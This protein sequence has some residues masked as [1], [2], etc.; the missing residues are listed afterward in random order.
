[1]GGTK[2][3]SGS[4]RYFQQSIAVSC[5]FFVASQAMRMR[6]V[7][8]CVTHLST[9]LLCTGL[10][11]PSV[12]LCTL[13]E[14]YNL[15]FVTQSTRSPAYTSR[16]SPCPPNTPLR[17]LSP[18]RHVAGRLRSTL[19]EW[20]VAFSQTSRRYTRR[21]SCSRARHI[22]SHFPGEQ[23]PARRPSG[24]TTSHQPLTTIRETKKTTYLI[25]TKRR[26]HLQRH[27]LPLQ[28]RPL[29][30]EEV[31]CLR[32]PASKEQ[33]IFDMRVL[34]TEFSAPHHP[35]IH[36]APHRRNARARP[37]HNHR[38]VDFVSCNPQSAFGYRYC[39]LVS[40]LQRLNVPRTHTLSDPLNHRLVFHN[41]N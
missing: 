3:E 7:Y 27:T 1:M 6:F 9:L 11:S 26:K 38:P 29:V 13:H 2:R 17:H 18:S 14:S 4:R 28:L 5:W 20:P 30:F 8:H 37:N 19:H 32:I 35:L 40:R 16:F 31:I 36:Q 10:H 34:H 23:D 24:A 12:F 15:F 21:R 41:R 33:Y 25:P 39:D 22:P